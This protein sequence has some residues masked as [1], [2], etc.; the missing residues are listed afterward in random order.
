MSR[1]LYL[2]TVFLM[3]RLK[4]ITNHKNPINP[5][6]KKWSPAPQFSFENQFHSNVCYNREKR[7]PQLLFC[8]TIDYG[9]SRVKGFF[10]LLL[11]Y[12]L[13]NQ[14]PHSLSSVLNEIELSFCAT[15]FENAVKS[16]RNY[17]TFCRN[18]AIGI[19][20]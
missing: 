18:V 6:M 13:Y 11:Q 12:V 2:E 3:S 14:S 17:V 20:F 16:A 9:H 5:R 8:T 4:W 19:L 10:F 1:G 15:H 7:Q